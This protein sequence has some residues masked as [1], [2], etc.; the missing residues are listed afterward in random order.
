MSARGF[1]LSLTAVL[2]FG[3][4]SVAT[5]IPANGSGS[6]CLALF[7]STC[8][9]VICALPQRIVVCFGGPS[10]FAPQA[11]GGGDGGDD[12]GGGDGSGGEGGASDGGAAGGN[13]DGT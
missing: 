5:P 8:R 9:T 12:G 10:V 7:Q 13:G 1:L 2:I 4:R 11:D 6:S 3:S